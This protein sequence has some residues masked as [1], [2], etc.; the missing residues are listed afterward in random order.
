V[1]LGVVDSGVAIGWITRSHRSL[2]KLNEL[3]DSCRARRL[4]LVVSLVN[5]VEILRHTAE[6][7]RVTG[8]DPIVLLRAQ[9]VELHVPDESVARRVARLPTLLADGF[10]AATA[11]ELGARL[12]T[13]D[14]EL[15]AQLK[16]TRITT[17][18]Y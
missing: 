4:R 1:K 6:S 3:F 5:L 8:H 12:H 18:H 17:T 14:R 15:I 11:L 9:G 7:A 13:T 16:T 10:A 2:A